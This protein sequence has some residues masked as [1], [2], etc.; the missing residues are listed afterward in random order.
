MH[1]TLCFHSCT[2]QPIVPKQEYL[3]DTETPFPEDSLAQIR[4][5]AIHPIPYH[6][7]AR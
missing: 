5:E 6:Y 3:A 7:A 4:P 1:K 2:F